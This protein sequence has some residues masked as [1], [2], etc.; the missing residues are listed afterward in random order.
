MWCGGGGAAAPSGQG[1][2]NASKPASEAGSR[3]FTAGSTGR[4]AAPRR[5]G[6]CPRCQGW[7]SRLRGV[8]RVGM[9]WWGWGWRAAVRALG[10]CAGTAQ[11]GGRLVLTAPAH[12]QCS[13]SVDISGPPLTAR[14]REGPQ[15]QLAAVLADGFGDL[16]NCHAGAGLVP[17]AVAG[18]ECVGRSAGTGWCDGGSAAGAAGCQVP[19]ARCRVPGARCRVPGARCRAAQGPGAHLM[20]PT[21]ECAVS[22]G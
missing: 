5:A 10:S 12:R 8:G 17:A 18:G 2:C 9:G 3:R 19:S 22:A 15:R 4:A 6:R 14:P 21:T 20:L 1:C 16:R 13:H 7:S 11:P